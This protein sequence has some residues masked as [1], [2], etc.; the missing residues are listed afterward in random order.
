MTLAVV[1]S[2]IGPTSF[3][4]VALQDLSFNQITTTGAEQLLASLRALVAQKRMGALR[5]LSIKRNLAEE[6]LLQEVRSMPP[7]CAIRSTRCLAKPNHGGGRWR[8]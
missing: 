5:R 4:R 2:L 1:P 7:R 8:E 3:S 6:G